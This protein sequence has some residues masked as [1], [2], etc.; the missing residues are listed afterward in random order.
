M[1]RYALTK[2]AQA[3]GL[4]ILAFVLL[5]IVGPWL[6]DLHSTPALILAVV[7][8]AGGA[9]VIAWFGWDLVTSMRNRGKVKWIRRY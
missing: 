1:R 7:L 4:L 2:A 3:V 8:L 5:R 6:I 9:F